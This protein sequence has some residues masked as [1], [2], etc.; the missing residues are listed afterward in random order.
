M[1]E[2]SNSQLA[3]Y[4][5]GHDDWLMI[6]RLWVQTSQIQCYHPQWSYGKV[7]FSRV[8]VCLQG[9]VSHAFSEEMGCGGYIWYHAPSKGWICLRVGTSRGW[10]CPEEGGYSPP[11]GW[12]CPGGGG[13]VWGW[14]WLG[15]GWVPIPLRYWVTMGHG[16]QVG[17]THFTGML[18]CYFNFL[19][20][21]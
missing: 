11:W 8:S 5:N 10:V 14:L 1:T 2:G 4:C 20:S 9:V 12:W 19:A 7:M 16:R 18:S 17:S 13:Y 21:N 3:L 6:S 15:G